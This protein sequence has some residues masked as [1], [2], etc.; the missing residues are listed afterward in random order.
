[1]LI[2]LNSDLGESFGNYT[3]GRDEEIIELVSSVNIACGWHGGDANVMADTVKQAIKKNVA[4]GCHPG[5]PDLMGFG[6][7]AMQVSPKELK[8]YIKYQIGALDAFVRS[9]GGRMQHVKP[10]GAMYNMAAKD[11]AMADAIAEAV[12]EVDSE[13]I[14]MGLSGSQLL[15]SAKTIGLKTASEVF[16]DRAYQNDGSLVPR[17]QEGALIHDGEKAVKQV[18]Q[19]IEKGTVT[20]LS[21]QEIPLVAESICVHGDNEKA[22]AFVRLIRQRLDQANIQVGALK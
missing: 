18:L 16:A 9:E 19:M 12:F 22:L 8:N 11:K 6:R 3:I 17:S 14:L 10:H 4:I 21:G 5:F 20:S 2:D 15:E 13:L 7:R 1:M